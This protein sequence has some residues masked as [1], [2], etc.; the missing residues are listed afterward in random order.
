M[1]VVLTQAVLEVLA[2]YFLFSLL[3]DMFEASTQKED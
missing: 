1:T 2:F 3:S